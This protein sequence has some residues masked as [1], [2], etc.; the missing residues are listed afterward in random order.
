MST[1]AEDV[2][3]GGG[4][5]DAT[6]DSPSAAAP[7]EAFDDQ[8]TAMASEKSQF[9]AFEVQGRELALPLD[10]IGEIIRPPAI[11]PVPL[12]PACLIGVFSLRGSVLPVVCLRRATGDEGDVDEDGQ[13][14]LVLR[15]QPRLGLRV[16]RVQRVFSAVAP[17]AAEQSSDAGDVALMTR[18]ALQDQSRILQLLDVDAVLKRQLGDWQQ[19]ANS[20]EGAVAERA[21]SPDGSHRQHQAER[22]VVSLRVAGQAFGLDALPVREILDC[23]EQISPVPRAPEAMLGLAAL[24]GATVPLFSLRRLLDFPETERGRRVVILPVGDAGLC[25]GLV[26]DDVEEVLRIPENDIG[27]VPQLNDAGTEEFAGVYRLPEGRG[28]HAGVGAGLLTLLD[29]EAF[30][31]TH[32]LA[33]MAER[34]V[35]RHGAKMGR[36]ARRS[37]RQETGNMRQ[38]VIFELEGQSF[39]APIG[40]VREI[41]RLPD[42]LTGVPSAGSQV[43]G[44]INLRGRVLPV[45]DMRRR[46]GLPVGQRDESQRVLVLDLS[47]Q[48]VGFIVDAVS[49]VLKVDEEQ[50]SDAREMAASRADWVAGVIRRSDDAGMVLV[51][52]QSRLL[53]AE[54][55]EELETVS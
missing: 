38:F 15:R 2:A 16:D 50:I 4:R 6:S 37:G 52:D 24:R 28:G 14:I 3:A 23:P 20:A 32:R 51:L 30:L 43:E 10:L 31:R 1:Q 42:K 46:F 22:I 17:E 53:E 36:D 5:A 44:V 11:T 41:L 13:R 8:H 21:E 29:V 48:R 35:D 54:T 49:E 55:L 26:V 19:S 39:G 7:L 18:G 47:G 25:I 34:M 27:P 45:V 12:S 40:I 9:L 33:A